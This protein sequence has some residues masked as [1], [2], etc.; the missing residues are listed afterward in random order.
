MHAIEAKYHANCLCKFY[1][2]LRT[3]E[4]QNKDYYEN[5]LKYS[6]AL[7]EVVNFI[8]KTLK[9]SQT[10]AAFIL[11]YLKQMF[12]KAYQTLHWYFNRPSQYTTERKT[13]F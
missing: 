13:Y 12:L 10:V 6:I 3:I 4:K 5:S 2:K 8:K 9:T 7:S 11:S 1:S